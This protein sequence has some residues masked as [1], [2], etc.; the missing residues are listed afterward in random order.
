M[1][2]YWCFVVCVSDILVSCAKMDELINMTFRDIDL[3]GPRYWRN[4]ALDNG[5]NCPWEGHFQQT[6]WLR[7]TRVCRH[8]IY[9]TCLTL[10]A[11][12]QQWCSIWLLIFDYCSSLYMPKR[13]CGT[14]WP[15]SNEYHRIGLH[16]LCLVSEY[17]LFF[18]D[19]DQKKGIWLENNR[20]L[21]Y[22]LLRSGVSS[23]F[24]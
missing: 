19:D 3:Q 12:R 1:A 21:E 20:N 24:S 17:G 5:P 9:Q 22:Y 13:L 15:L 2:Y 11:S 23:F 14:E 7:H 18:A 8:L 10:F 4:L 16:W 6:H